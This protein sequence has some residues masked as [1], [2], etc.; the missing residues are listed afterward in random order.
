MSNSNQGQATP[1]T[2]IPVAAGKHSPTLG[3]QPV[4]GILK[5]PAT[6]ALDE[7]APRYALID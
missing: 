4:K 5:R 1:A 7:R 6:Q 2:S 3:A